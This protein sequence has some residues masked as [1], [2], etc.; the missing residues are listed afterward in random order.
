MT[1][2]LP[3][4]IAAGAL[5]GAFGY[6]LTIQADNRA[7]RA[8]R[9]V[10]EAQLAGCSA[11]SGNITEDKESDDEIDRI[12]DADLRERAGEWVFEPA[13]NPDQH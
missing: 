4:L 3:H 5:L 12:P 2:F 7:L 11:R 6:V 13:G 1:R 8:S 9:A 10:L